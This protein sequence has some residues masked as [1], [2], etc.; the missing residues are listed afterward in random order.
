MNRSPDASATRA[1][2]TAAWRHRRAGFSLVEILVALAIVGAILGLGAGALRQGADA[3]ARAARA[4][5]A[6]Q[7]AQARL[8]AAGI[9]E[10]LTAGRSAGQEPGGTRWRMTV[11][12]VDLPAGSAAT[13]P[14]LFRV[15]V[16]VVW[17]DG[18][19]ER[20]VELAT[21]RLEPAAR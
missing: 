12:P 20:R 11:E 18:R 8:T 19:A 15:A 6:L 5:A 9:E 21:H 4:D 7:V 10:A 14:K 13:G 3:A 17:R 1:E 2:G 16:E